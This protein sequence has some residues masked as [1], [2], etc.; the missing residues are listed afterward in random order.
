[1]N[2]LEEALVRL[3]KKRGREEMTPEQAEN[4]M[5]ELICRMTTAADEDGETIRKNMAKARLQRMMEKEKSQPN[6]LG[7]KENHQRFAKLFKIA[8]FPNSKEMMKSFWDEKTEKDEVVKSF[9]SKK[10]R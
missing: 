9:S 7:K 6:F 3:K 5:E 2:P 1:M 4:V 10:A 8:E